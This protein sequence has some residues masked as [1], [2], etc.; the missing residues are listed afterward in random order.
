MAVEESVIETLIQIAGTTRKGRF[1]AGVVA[2]NGRVI[3]T[4]PIVR[5]MMGWTGQQ[6]AQYCR[7][8]GWTWQKIHEIRS[9]DASRR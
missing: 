6:V 9:D 1:H 7:E 5:K 8:Q 2:R 4:A 3:A